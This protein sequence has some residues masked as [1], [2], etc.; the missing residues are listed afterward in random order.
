MTFRA[1]SVHHLG[2]NPTRNGRETSQGSLILQ[3][4]ARNAGSRRHAHSILIAQ[5][6][7][8]T[9]SE[10]VQSPRS[11]TGRELQQ[12]PDFHK[13]S[14]RLRPGRVRPIAKQS[15]LRFIL[16]TD[17]RSQRRGRE[18][19]IA[20]REAHF[21]RWKVALREMSPA[22]LVVIILD[23]GVLIGFEHREH[24]WLDRR[25]VQII[26]VTRGE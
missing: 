21:V 1:T 11:R 19:R 14:L 26:I 3:S 16:R 13:P 10:P 24:F 7:D 12:L 22:D 4:Q 6:I 2:I 25:L 5:V 9:L 17:L 15:A 23:V 18:E 20:L 8:T